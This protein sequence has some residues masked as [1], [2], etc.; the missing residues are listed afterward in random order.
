MAVTVSTAVVGSG[1]GVATGIGAA[2]AKAVGIGDATGTA[3][4][5]A[6]GAGASAELRVVTGVGI[7]MAALVA[8]IAATVRAE[9]SGVAATALDVV[10]A[11]VGSA[12][13]EDAKRARMARAGKTIARWN[14]AT[15]RDTESLRL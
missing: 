1:R 3:G 8:N 7:G 6:G 4:E 2:V 15:V 13:H 11:C 10:G 12:A 5:V 14:E 9:M